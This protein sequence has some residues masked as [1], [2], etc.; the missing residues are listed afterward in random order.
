VPDIGKLLWPKS[1]AVVGA[2]SDIHGLRGRILEIIL[3]HPFAGKIYPVSRSAAEVQGLRAYASVDELPEPVDLAIVIIPAAYVPAELERCGRADIKAAVILSSGFAEEPGNVGAHM[4]SE[5]AAIA[6]RYD[7]A[8]SGPNTEGFANI[9]A[10]FCPTFSPA[11]D[12]SA[13]PLLPARSLGRG[14][15]SVISQSGGLGFAFFD[16]ARSRNLSF[17]HIVT[18]GNEAALEVAD[19]IDYMLDEDKTDVFL[20]LIE[21]VKT[22]EKFIRVAEKAL[23]ASKPLIVA[24]I[25]HSGSG[26]RA[27]ASHTAALAGSQAAYRAIFERYGLIEGRDFDEMIDLAVGFLACGDRL[28]AGNRVGICTSSGGAGVWMADACDAARLEVPVLD[29]KTRAAIDIHLPSYGTSQN[30]VDSTAQGVHKLGYAEFARLIAQSP[31][32]DGV[33]VAVTAR[34]SAF[35]ENDL[36]KLKDLARDSTKPVFMWTYTLPSARS[37][38]ILNEAGYP[39]FT[40][41]HGC[42]RTM[43]AL[44]D[45]RALRERLLRPSATT[46][47]RVTGR[48]KVRAMLADSDSVLCEYRARPLLSAYGIGDENA[49]YLVHS[50]DEAAAATRAIGQAVALKVQSADIPHKT[51]AGAVTLNLSGDAVR[52]GY[53]RVLAAAKRHSPTARIDGVL[54]QPMAAPGREVILGI[55]RDP[56]WGPLLMVGLGGVLVEAVGDMALATVPLDNAAAHALIA[57]LKGAQVFGPYRGAPPADVDALAE[58]MVRLS[59]FA[60]DFSD[61]ISQID[62]NPVLVHASGKGVTVVDAL[63]IKRNAHTERHAAAE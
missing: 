11:M 41:A 46:T 58:L 49:G 32:I 13:G 42:A 23:K 14:Q 15:V 38:E 56:T 48:E 62:L 54:V 29:E 39:L 45:Y 16:R 20:L 60:T 28:P 24:K 35:L 25:G 37:I 40:G 3:S 1:V 33:I 27:V 47:Q 53:N 10:A 34:R 43:R 51:E 52:D 4:Q 17:R 59:Q 30:P 8:V 19:F 36:Q 21:D 12:K 22:S 63:V 31:Q 57:R 44:A 50:P 18:T 7:M 6:R 61:Y 2:S 5:I 9:A 55:N 26:S